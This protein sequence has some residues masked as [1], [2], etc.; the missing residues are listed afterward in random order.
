MKPILN[1]KKRPKDSTFESRNWKS[2]GLTRL[3][4][5]ITLFKGNFVKDVT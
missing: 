2:R 1:D 5:K 3:Y 4:T